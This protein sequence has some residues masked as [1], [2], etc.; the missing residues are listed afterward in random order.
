[1]K[2]KKPNRLLRQMLQV[3]SFRLQGGGFTLIETIIYI[4]LFSLVTGFVM[5]VFYQLLAGQGKHRSR[6]E[7]DQEANFIMQKMLWA[8][9]GAERILQ[10]SGGATSTTLTV[11]SAVVGE[12]LVTFDINSNNLR[13]TQPDSSSAILNSSRVSVD[14]LIFTHINSIEGSPEGVKIRLR[15][16]SS[17][18]AVREASS[19][20]EHTIYFRT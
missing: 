10:P 20:L 1:M 11:D 8:L 14:E 18:A 4:V 3:S 5:I 17:G 6:V 7:V 15:V 12:N 9:T 13:I 19:T 2:L 16:V